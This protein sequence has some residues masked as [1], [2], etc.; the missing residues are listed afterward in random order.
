MSQRNYKSVVNYEDHD[1]LTAAFNKGEVSH[2]HIYHVVNSGVFYRLDY[3]GRGFVEMSDPNDPSYDNIFIWWIDK[4]HLMAINWQIEQ[5]DNGQIN[6][7]PLPGHL[8]MA[9][10]QINRGT[11]FDGRLVVPIPMRNTVDVDHLDDVTDA[12]SLKAVLCNQFIGVPIEM[13]HYDKVKHYAGIITNMD[14]SQIDLCAM[15]EKLLKN[16]N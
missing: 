14:L 7:P 6:M 16:G 11:A 12:Q 13:V 10:G 2:D 15:R 8:R 9:I 1:Q 3:S 5:G 4:Y